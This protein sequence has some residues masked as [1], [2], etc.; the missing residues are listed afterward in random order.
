MRNRKQSIILTLLCLMIISVTFGQNISNNEYGNKLSLANDSLEKVYIY[1]DIVTELKQSSL[2]LAIDFN[3]KALKLANQINSADACGATNE[4]MGELYGKKNNVQPAI[5]YYLISAKIYEELNNYRKLSSIYGNLGKLYYNNNYDT[6]RTL[7]YYRK[8]LDYAVQ[9]NDKNLIAEAY[10]RIGGIL[11]NQQ[12]YNDALYYFNNALEIF[13]TISNIENA[14]ITLNNIGDVYRMRGIM[15]EALQYYRRSIDI[16]KSMENTILMAI[17]YVNIGQ[18]YS[19]KGINDQAFDYYAKSLE[20]YESINDINGL[21][22]L[23]NLLAAEY[24]ETNKIEGAFSAYQNSFQLAIENN[25]WTQI[26]QSSLGLSKIYEINNDHINSLKYLHIYARYNDSIIKKQMSDELY[27]LQTHFLRSISEKEIQIKDADIELLESEQEINNL[28]QNFLIFGVIALIIVS[29]V[30]IIRMKNRIKKE[31]LINQK[32][33]QLHETQK[34]LLK[35]ELANKDN[36]LINFALHLVQKNEVLKQLKSDLNK[37]STNE[38]DE[39]NRR[40][41]ELSIHIQQS[42]Q[43]NKE[44]QEF[45]EKVDLTYDD[46]FNKLKMRFPQLSKN[47]KRLCAL[48]RL[49]LSSKEISSLNNTSVRAVEMSRY[50]LRKKCNIDSQESLT[51]YLQNL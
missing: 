8:S 12:N 11:H 3:K 46:F 6:E 43:V 42:L 48:L 47:E 51:E 18:I 16:S 14:A 38:D 21:S 35:L 1:H 15:D 22:A 27:D 10:N 36:D 2:D 34:E 37:I 28:K 40:I 30:S 50:R 44:L 32:D 7:F 9:I 13:E 39:F 49:N 41:K 5:N 19:H 20:L 29:V 25:Q 4:L 26:K 24:L 33:R 45:Q 23:Y 31:R 17:T